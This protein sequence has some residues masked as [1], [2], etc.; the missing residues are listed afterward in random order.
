MAQIEKKSLVDQVYETLK[1]EIVTLKRAPGA[2]LNV[3]AIQ[4]QLDVSC[5]PVRESV[6]RLQQEGLITYKNNIG[7]HVIALNL[8]DIDEIMQ[9]GNTL[10]GTAIRLAMQNGN[11]DAIIASLEKW[12]NN[13]CN[14]TDEQEEILAVHNL[15]GTFYWNCGNRRL[16]QS[17]SALRAQ[18]LIVRNM[19]AK[20]SSKRAEEAD[21]LKKIVEL[22]KQGETEALCNTMEE[23][24]A[25]ISM[26]AKRFLQ[27]N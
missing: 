18:Q 1:N 22:A 17:M 23:Y 14:A 4:Q 10:H 2:K 7:A 8:H 13:Y 3:A 11:R 24:S 5:T 25:I 21:L 20:M 19:A 12:C 16:D 27:A 6:N 26:K 9:L 15:V